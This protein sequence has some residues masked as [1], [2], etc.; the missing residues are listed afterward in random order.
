MKTASLI[1]FLLVACSTFGAT[2]DI[3]S[4]VTEPKS[5]KKL[6]NRIDPD[7]HVYGIPLGTTEDQF[8]EDYGK[9]TGYL[10]LNS[11]DT[12][13]IYGKS[14]AFMFEHGKLAGVRI[15]RTIV[16]WKLLTRSVGSTPF[17]AIE[18][19]LTNNIDSEM[20]LKEVKKI[21]GDKL[22][23]DPSRRYYLTD[24]MRVELDF[25]HY[26]SEGQTDQAHKVCGV[27]VR[28]K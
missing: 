20:N 22:S 24:R 11:E 10:R 7:N 27:F 19:R 23:L 2:N 12:V 8:I 25:S 13:M 14:H 4:K 15:T 6:S 17:D 28:P 18:W 1:T 16:D 21:L 3:R 5:Y 26:T 9:A